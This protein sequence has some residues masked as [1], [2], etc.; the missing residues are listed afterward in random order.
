[1]SCSPRGPAQSR[2]DEDRAAN[3]P[4]HG[5]RTALRIA[6]PANPVVALAVMTGS[7]ELP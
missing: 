4:R 6:I 3:R 1:M 5:A 2:R 7:S